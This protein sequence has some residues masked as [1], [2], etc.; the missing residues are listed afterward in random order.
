MSSD[1][2]EFDT[3]V[4]TYQTDPFN[5]PTPHQAVLDVVEALLAMGC[6]EVSLGDTVGVGVA[7]DVK[8]LLNY[9]Q[10]AGVPLSKLA[11]HFHDTYGQA[12]SNVW[13]AY[14]CGLRVF[15]SSVGGLGGCPFAPGAKGNVATEDLVYMFHQAGVDTGVDLN[16]LVET[17]AW[18]SS[19]LS[20]VNDSRAGAA[21]LA[22]AASG[23]KAAVGSSAP[24]TKI[25]WQDW[26]N[27]EGIIIQRAGVNV[28]IVM[29][30]PRNGNALTFKMI[31]ELTT[32]FDEAAHDE[33]ITRIVLTGGGKFF[34]TGMDLAKDSTA[35]GSDDLNAKQYT[36]LSRLFKAIDEAPQVTIAAI[37]GPAFGGGIGLAFACDIRISVSTDVTLSEV[38]LGLAP[39]TIS[40]YVI[41]EWGA[42]FARE[43]MLSGRRISMTELQ[44]RGV[45]AAVATN[46]QQ[47]AEMVDNYLVQ[48]KSS[49]STG[50][51]LS[52]E[53]VRLSIAGGETQVKGVKKVFEEMMKPGAQGDIG[54]KHF[55]KTKK[56]MDWDAYG[57]RREKAKL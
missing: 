30:R 21:L 46:Q 39:A 1:F 13:T 17:G 48:L 52:K 41:R 10:N 19:K 9:L 47:L 22:K 18:I 57:L 29:N 36:S 56:Y 16:K 37:N 7:S 28:K 34:C 6:Y 12:V 24:A 44:N 11:G 53:L 4:L 25:D 35:V 51:K 38:K 20:K 26:R 31:D 5:G 27:G 14:Q 49:S 3:I 33:T 54:V 45:V 2:C 50:S 32:F 40:P 8:S 55:Q 43:A 42:A 15:D 23:K